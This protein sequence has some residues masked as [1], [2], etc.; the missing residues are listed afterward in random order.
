MTDRNVQW[1]NRYQLTKVPG[2]DDIYDLTPAPGTITAEGTMINK[3]SL[4]TDETAQA[5][6]FPAEQLADVV[7]DDVFTIM[8]NATLY[9]D[10]QLKLPNGVGLPFVQ[11]EVGTY[12]GT[13]TY[14]INAQN[15]LTF[16]FVPKLIIVQGNGTPPGYSYG[17]NMSRFYAINGLTYA[18]SHEEFNANL[19]VARSI[20]L[21][22]NGKTVNWYSN[23]IEGQLNSSGST[24]RYVAFS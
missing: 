16:S 1:P 8:S 17:C 12:V 24:Y 14:G 18:T 23:T 20:M 4:L 5:F 13:G 2:T 19:T 11:I 10:G 21:I 3:A 15:S 7:P 9:K 22:W 6:G